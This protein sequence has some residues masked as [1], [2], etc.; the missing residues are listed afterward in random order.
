MIIFLILI[1]IKT[2]DNLNWIFDQPSHRAKYTV[3]LLKGHYFL[4]WKET[5][6]DGI[7]YQTSWRHEPLQYI[8]SNFLCYNKFVILFAS[9]FAKFFPFCL[10]MIG[11]IILLIFSPQTA[12]WG[13]NEWNI[14]ISLRFAV[15]FYVMI[16]FCVF[17]IL[18]VLAWLLFVFTI[19]E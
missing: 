18:S 8:Y 7:H 16:Q 5:L 4:F 2:L 10:L 19:V 14:H 13:I 6:V 15:D 9:V 3:L 1:T 12:L 11:R 17:F